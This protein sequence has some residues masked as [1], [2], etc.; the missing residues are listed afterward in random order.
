MLV[1]IVLLITINIKKHWKFSITEIEEW[2]LSESTV[3][4]LKFFKERK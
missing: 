3:S 1:V 4:T 2:E